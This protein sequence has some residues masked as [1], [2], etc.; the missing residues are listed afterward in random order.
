MVLHG[1]GSQVLS[2]WWSTITF[3]KLFQKATT[4]VDQSV[5]LIF[6]EWEQGQ[7]FVYKSMATILSAKK[8]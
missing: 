7:V 8:I 6:R 2:D 3:K 4:G 1:N 5:Q